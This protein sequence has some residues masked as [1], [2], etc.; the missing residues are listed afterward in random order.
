MTTLT[1]NDVY[2]IF[3]AG[4][5]DP[6]WVNYTAADIADIEDHEVNAAADAAAYTAQIPISSARSIGYARTMLVRTGGAPPTLA[7]AKATR[8]AAIIA[9]GQ[10]DLA[11][12]FYSAA[13]GQGRWYG[14]T[15]SEVAGLGVVSGM[16]FQTGTDLG[17][18]WKARFLTS[19][20]RGGALY[21]T[22]VSKS[23]SKTLCLD[24]D[25]ARLDHMN[26]M[27]SAFDAIDNATTV[28]AVEAVTYS[29]A[30]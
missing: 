26:R 20:T 18:T 29:W 14:S 7:E 9:E 24:F 13:D 3:I 1:T 25:A 5:P 15:A 22:A 11:R 2:P 12:G 19:D 4:R 16:V 27:S 10:A 17:A 23:Q 21:I 28:A 30:P 6:V 8:R